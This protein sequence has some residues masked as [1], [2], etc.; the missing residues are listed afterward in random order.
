MGVRWQFS[1]GTPVFMIKNHPKW[2]MQEQSSMCS[3]DFG[4]SSKNFS[5]HP[6]KMDFPGETCPG[7][8]HF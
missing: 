1:S 8:P 3:P 4:G 2:G 5:K 6:P 7:T